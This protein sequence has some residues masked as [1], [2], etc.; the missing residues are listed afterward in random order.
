MSFRPF[1]IWDNQTKR[2]VENSVSLHCMSNWR[3]C[4]FTGEI[5]DFVQP[6]DSDHYSN[7]NATANPDYYFDDGLIKAP[8]YEKHQWTG[9]HD[10]NGRKI[11]EGDI[12]RHAGNLGEIKFRNGGYYC[13]EYPVCLTTSDM[14]ENLGFPKEKK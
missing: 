9:L 6:I 3:I 4:P 5:T 1:R 14:L 12:V 10:K 13:G 8:R 7:Y 2:F 11:Y